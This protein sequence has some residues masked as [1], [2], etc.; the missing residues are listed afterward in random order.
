MSEFIP[1]ELRLSAVVLAEELE[2]S[3]AAQRLGTSPATLHARIVELA[4]LPEFSFFKRR[5][6]ISR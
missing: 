3:K 6:I 1:I 2:F 4:T 5:A